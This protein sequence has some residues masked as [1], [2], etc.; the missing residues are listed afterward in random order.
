M[1]VIPMEE[2]EQ[3]IYQM[4]KEMRKKDDEIETLKKKIEGLKSEL[5]EAEAKVEKK[6]EKLEKEEKKV[7]DELEST[8]AK[9]E[10]GLNNPNIPSSAKETIKKKIAAAKEEL[11]KQKGTTFLYKMLS[12]LGVVSTFLLIIKP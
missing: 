11:S 9:L 5:K 6:E 12:M 4:K 7:Q 3:L 1:E 8:I 2:F 10:K